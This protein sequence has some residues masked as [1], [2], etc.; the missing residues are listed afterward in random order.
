MKTFRSSRLS[1]AHR[2]RLT[3]RNPVNDQAAERTARRICLDVK[4]RGN[5][6]VSDFSTRFD[7]VSPQ[8]RRIPD[9]ALNKASRR[10]KPEFMQALRNAAATITRFHEQQNSSQRPVRTM[11]GV[12]CWRTITAIPRVGLYVP[13]GSAPL[14]STVLMLGIPALL[15]G[16]NS[17]ALFTPPSSNGLANPFVLAAAAVAGIREIY[18]VGG[19]QAIAAMAYGT[20]SVPRVDK[21]FGP[22]NRFVNLAKQIVAADPEGC[23][24]DMPA[25]PSELLVIA[26]ADAN[27]AY[28]AAD[29]LSQAEHDPD[30]RV[31]LVTT[32]EL[33]ARRALAEIASQLKDLPRK[34]IVRRSLAAGFV[35][36]VRSLSE[37]MR[38]SNEYAPEH[39]SI[40][41][42]RP[43]ALARHVRNAGSVFL[44]ASAPVA[45]GDYAS[46]TNHTLPTGGRARAYSGLTVGS[47]Q[48]SVS[49]QSLT[50]AGLG[51]LAGTIK[52]LAA[53]EG[54]EAHR[55]SITVREH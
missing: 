19:A 30:A 13:A 10:M 29:L 48:K 5:A 46:G 20:E 15:A 52:S 34:T 7:G 6:A 8:I 31:A 40:Q 3:V 18:P 12:T 24:I 49:F 28:V 1:A 36:I 41:T 35:L 16:C 27:P 43:E 55:R 9:S 11:P 14:P 51:R 37:A 54:L 2:R 32:S 25:G 53:A 33:L 4:Q 44:G 50:R 47:F 26:D 23:A 42:A 22:G 39:L 38:F 17:I 21:I 45:A